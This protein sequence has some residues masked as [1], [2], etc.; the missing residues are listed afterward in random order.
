MTN[1]QWM[2]LYLQAW[3][4]GHEDWQFHWPNL[5]KKLLVVAHTTQF[6]D[7]PVGYLFNIHL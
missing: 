1:E 3:W 6:S 5:W 2:Q 4:I 7:R